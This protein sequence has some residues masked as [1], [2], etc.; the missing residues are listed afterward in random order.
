M[1][2]EETAML[3]LYLAGCVAKVVLVAILSV[4]L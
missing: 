3:K 2:R 1:E 4:V